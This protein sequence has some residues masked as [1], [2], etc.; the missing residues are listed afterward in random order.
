MR[1]LHLSARWTSGENGALDDGVDLNEGAAA[2][3]P[4]SAEASGAALLTGLGAALEGRPPTA[5]AARAEARLVKAVGRAIADWQMIEA[6]DR[7]MVAVSGGKDSYTML[8][9][10][11]RLR[12]RAPVDFSLVAV[13]LDQGHPG[14]PG[15][16]LADWLAAHG[17][18]HHMLHAD[19]YSVVKEKVPAGKTT[20]SLCSRLRRGVLY[21]AAQALGCTKIALGHHRGDLIETLL[22]NLFY[23]GQLKAMPP[24]LH[25]DDGRNVVIRPLSYCDE[26]DIVLFAEQQAFPIIPC[27]LCGSQENLQRKRVKGLI[28]E[29]QRENGA[30]PGNML[31]ALQNVRPSHLL[32]PRLRAAAGLD[33][34][35]GAPRGEDEA[36][37]RLR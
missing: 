27:D 12:R 34:A 30:V 36:I 19:T 17:F 16:L 32:D 4:F 37:D 6:G 25:S 22:L 20:C 9:L 23:A 29:L 33:G 21:N 13:N 14:Y 35:G 5:A 15:H 24:V 26:E 11:E 31:A 1:P 2:A 10:L 8:A 18:E 7:V 3:D 28:R